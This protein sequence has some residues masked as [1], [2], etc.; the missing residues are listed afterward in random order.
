LKRLNGNKIDKQ[1]LCNSSAKL[2]PS[3][4]C[5]SNVVAIAE[6]LLGKILF[7]HFNNTLTAARIV[8]TEA[9]NGIT[10]KASH[11]FGGR[12]TARTATMYL[13]GGT[14]YV[15]LCYGIHHLFN[16]VTNTENIPHAILIRAAEPVF[17]VETM[18]A[19]TGKLVLDHTITRGPGNLSKALG[20]TTK[21]NSIFL[22]GNE[23]Y[24]TDD[25]FTVE[26]DTITESPRIGVDYAG[27]DALL[28]YRFHIKGNPYVSG[29]NN[30][31]ETSLNKAV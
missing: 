16:V 13:R 24:I 7:T 27:E 2:G 31:T 5:R 14:T 25:G 22:T 1:I 9:Y 19:R 28:P 29:K 3:F 8:E 11:A 18:L 21:H 20:I 12:R 30:K 15:Y 4:Y 6:E 10:D 17:G 23:I 26:K